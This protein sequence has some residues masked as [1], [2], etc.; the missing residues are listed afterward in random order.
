MTA[1]PPRIDRRKRVRK[2]LG[3]RSEIAVILGCILFALVIVW[4]AA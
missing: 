2:F 4:W 3:A 1:P